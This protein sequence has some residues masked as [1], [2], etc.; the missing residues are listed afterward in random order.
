MP[1]PT[2]KA[3][4]TVYKGVSF[5]SRLEARAAAAFDRQRWAWR[6]EYD[7]YQAGGTG[8]VP[9]FYI[10]EPDSGLDYWVEV[11][12]NQAAVDDDHKARQFARTTSDP[13]FYAIEGESFLHRPEDP[14]DSEVWVSPLRLWRIDPYARQLVDMR[15][16]LILP[17]YQDGR[18]LWPGDE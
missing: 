3:K 8:Y 6:Y 9:D 5:R 1:E 4:P 11:K 13:V 12:P 16:F 17:Q 2:I 15:R 7:T 14:W 18:M 10:V